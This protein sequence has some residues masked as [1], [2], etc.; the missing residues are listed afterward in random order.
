MVY[1]QNI[2][3]KKVNT[4]EEME[5]NYHSGMK[6]RTTAATDMNAHSSRSHL[7]FSI[8][9]KTKNTQSGTK[10][11]G[12]LTLVDLAGSERVSKSGATADRLK[13]ILNIPMVTHL[14]SQID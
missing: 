5:E 13:V 3:T 12:K 7:V 4:V 10:S 8:L 14:G 6:M 9:I 11:M 1:I 2:V